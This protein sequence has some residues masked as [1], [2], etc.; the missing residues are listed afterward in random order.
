MIAMI[1]SIIAI[2]INAILLIRLSKIRTVYKNMKSELN[3]AADEGIISNREF[4]KS[5]D[6]TMA[7][8]KQDKHEPELIDIP[9]HNTITT[10]IE[11]PVELEP[12]DICGGENGE[13]N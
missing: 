4:L 9:T 6:D 12:L 11:K 2:I 13:T 7:Y 1:L 5:I 3:K 10:K 8:L